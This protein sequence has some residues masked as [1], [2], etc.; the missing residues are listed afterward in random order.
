M[1]Y[2]RNKRRPRNRGTHGCRCKG[3]VK[4][5]RCSAATAMVSA[6]TAEFRRWLPRCRRTIGDMRRVSECTSIG[7]VTVRLGERAAEWLKQRKDKT[8]VRF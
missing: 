8:A 6:A 4:V 5:K 2:N 7:E 3:S 1:T